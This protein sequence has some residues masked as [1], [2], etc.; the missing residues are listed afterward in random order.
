MKNKNIV[1]SKTPHRVGL[2]GGGTDLP[3]YFRENAG[4]VINF[5]IDK[6]IYVI[7][8][9]HSTFYNEKFRINYSKT[10][11]TDNVNQIENN[12]V[13]ET[14]KYFSIDFPIYIETNSDIPSSSGMGSS[15]AFCVGLINCI[16]DLLYLNLSR[17]DIAEIACDIEIN[18]VGSPIGKQDQ[19]AASFG[20]INLF[21][22]FKN[23]K[24]TIDPI[25]KTPLFEKAL[26]NNGYLLWTNIQRDANSVLN[27]Q[28]SL[29]KNKSMLYN[30][31]TDL[32]ESLYEIIYDKKLSVEDIYILLRK[33]WE[34]KKNLS[35]TILNIKLNSVIDDITQISQHHKITGAGGGGFIYLNP[36]D[37]NSEQFINLS[38]KYSIE[39][40]NLCTKG[41]EIIYAK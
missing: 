35:D 1:I 5:T 16:S 24:V 33:A 11:I 18:H 7:L 36:F 3:L 20:G 37:A 8:K 41:T 10:E 15:S 28:N 14:L 23:G 30:Q 27:R 19:Y 13:R 29:I 4:A 17:L 38:K 40:F 9:R 6:Y 34:I 12:I 32:T 25:S 26:I 21:R 22:F 39:K 31:L 2:I